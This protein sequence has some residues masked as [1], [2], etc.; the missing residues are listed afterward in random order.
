MKL[1]FGLPVGGAWATPDALAAVAQAAERLRYHPLWGF[2]RLPFPP[3]P[4]GGDAG[5]PAGGPPV[6]RRPHAA[7]PPG[8]QRAA[9]AVLLAGRAR[10][11]ARDARRALRRPARRRARRRLVP[12]RV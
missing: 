7:D 1:G 6:R 5:R 3:A 2:P 9:R 12:R 8:R 11:A 4:R 10:Q